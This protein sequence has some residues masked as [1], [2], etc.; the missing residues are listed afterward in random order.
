MQLQR[1]EG[2]TV[3]VSKVKSD[4]GLKRIFNL[5]YFKSPGVRARLVQML[6]EIKPAE[7]KFIESAQAGNNVQI[8]LIAQV[9][10]LPRFGPLFSYLD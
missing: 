1:V 7:Y 4:A 8:G 3:Y 6:K 5:D 2:P 10:L 9:R